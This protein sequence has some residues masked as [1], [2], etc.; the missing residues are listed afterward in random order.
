[1]SVSF[2][3]YRIGREGRRE[4]VCSTQSAREAR[5]ARDADQGDML[6]VSRDDASLQDRRARP[7]K[8]KSVAPKVANEI[9]GDFPI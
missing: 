8:I 7:R 5:E 2:D 4:L 9:E 6:V 3:V 1:M